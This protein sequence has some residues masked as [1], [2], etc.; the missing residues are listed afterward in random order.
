MGETSA[1]HSRLKR[2]RHRLSFLGG[3]RFAIPSV[4]SS[5]RSTGSFLTSISSTTII[6]VM[7]S[8]SK[9]MPHQCRFATTS[10]PSPISSTS[11][12]S[13]SSRMSVSHPQTT[14][15]RIIRSDVSVDQHKDGSR[16]CRALSGIH[17]HG[18]ETS[19]F[20]RVSVAYEPVLGRRLAHASVLVALCRS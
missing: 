8:S 16:T 11:V 18:T 13:N 5:R 1:S 4:P 12:L 17:L 2:S 15:T 3:R 20:S 7:G 6:N 10:S 9:T 14:F 19:P